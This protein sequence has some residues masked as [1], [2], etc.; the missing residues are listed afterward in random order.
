MGLVLVLAVGGVGGSVFG[1]WRRGADWCCLI[2]GWM[3]G[4]MNILFYFVLFRF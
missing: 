1:G 2:D 4:L 3:D